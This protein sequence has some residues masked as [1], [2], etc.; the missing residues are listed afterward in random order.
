MARYDDENN[1]DH[2]YLFR[3]ITDSIRAALAFEYWMKMSVSHN[4]ALHDSQQSTAG[5]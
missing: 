4:I 5:R 1:D 2:Y 3:V